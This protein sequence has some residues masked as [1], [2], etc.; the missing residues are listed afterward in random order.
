[1]V[2]VHRGRPPQTWRVS[3]ESTRARESSSSGHTVHSNT[4]DQIEPAKAST[5]RQQEVPAASG[6]KMNILQRQIDGITLVD[7][8]GR[9]DSSVSGQVM[10]QLN[11]IVNSGVTRLIVN[12]RHVSYISSAGLRSIL[13]AAKLVRS[14]N[15]EMRLC[16]PNGLLKRTLEESGFA[17]LIRIDDEEGQSIAALR[18]P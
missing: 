3:G 8:S 6:M 2:A 11:E 1:M 4:Q 15:G 7:L 10:D 14:G 17:N 5:R 9:L 16:Q 13:V 12:L 18:A